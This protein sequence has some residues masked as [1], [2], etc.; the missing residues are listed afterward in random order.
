MELE[1]DKHF[2]MKRINLLS[3]LTTLSKRVCMT[4]DRYKTIKAFPE[5]TFCCQQNTFTIRK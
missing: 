4:K 5:T 1:L 2:L 3:K